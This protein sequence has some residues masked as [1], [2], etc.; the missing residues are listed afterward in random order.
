MD[1][2]S[3]MKAFVRVVEA[4]TF[5]KAADT[6]GLP[7]A[8][9]TRLVQSLE[10]TLR[11]QLLNCSTRRVIATRDGATYYESAVRLLQEMEDVESRYPMPSCTPGAGCVSMFT[12]CIAHKILLPA[13]DDFCA[14]Y[15]DIQV[16]MGVSDRPVDL[17]GEN[18]DCALRAGQVTNPALVAR[19]VG[20]IR[21]MLCASSAYLE[22]LGVPQSPPDLEDGRHRVIS[23]FHSGRV[24]F[25]Y[26]LRRG[27]EKYH[28]VPTSTIAVDDAEA[29]L[30][31]ALAG[32]GVTVTSMFVAAPHLA[33]GTLRQVL[34]EWDAGTAPLHIVYPPT[35]RVSAKVRVFIDWVAEL[36]SRTLQES[37]ARDVFTGQ[38]RSTE[39]SVVNTRTL[40]A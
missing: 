25:E 1:K 37:T 36:L 4:G 2:L 34:P 26:V 7:K 19:R 22:R 31:A 35:R 12:S 16:D 8:Q 11:T 10:Q 21:L 27:D 14:R 30:S 28:V 3:A 33:A 20:G 13:M 9:V 17:I 18:V 38:R 23:F 15:P 6:I 5:T 29:L 24:R 39:T 40:P 32:L